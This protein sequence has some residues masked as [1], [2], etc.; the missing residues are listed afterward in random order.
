MQKREVSKRRAHIADAVAAAGRRAKDPRLAALTTSIRL[1]AFTEVK[2]KLQ[3]MIDTLSA[4]KEEEIAHKDAC[5]DQFNK[6][7]LH[8]EENT[9]S[10]D[11][12]NAKIEDLTQTVAA[13]TKAVATLKQEIADLKENMKRGGEDREIANKAFQEIADLKENMKRA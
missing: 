7:S 9:R 12:L 13:L 3:K 2:A 6:N 10:K 4:E 1:N 11:S 8:T 5:V